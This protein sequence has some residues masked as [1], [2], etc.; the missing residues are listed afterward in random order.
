MN[1]KYFIELEDKE[2]ESLS[3]GLC[4]IVKTYC[5]DGE[6]CTQEFDKFLVTIMGG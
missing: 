2:A 4:I 5:P 6:I 1:N 3:G